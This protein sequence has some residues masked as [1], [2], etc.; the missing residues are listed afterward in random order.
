MKRPCT[1][2]IVVG[3]RFYSVCM[4]QS[5][6][7]F[8]RVWISVALFAA[9]MVGLIG[10]A[11][12]TGWRET[13]DAFGRLSLAQFSILLGLSLLNYGFRCA[14]WHIYIR[15][16][17]IPLSLMSNARHYLGG[18]ALTATPGRVG[19]LIRLRW[20]WRETGRRP[21][22]T[23]SLV[24]VDRAADLTA[25]GLILAL[26]IAVSTVGIQGAW[27]VSIVALL[28]AW[29]ATRPVLFRAVITIGWK[30]LG[31]FPRFFAMLRR[32]ANGL[33]V[34]SV[35]SVFVPTTICGMIGWLAEGYAFYLLLHWM[36]AG[37]ELPT[38]VA[39]FFFAM[40]S[41]SASGLPGGIGGA[42]A[43]M[44]ALLSYQGV[45]LEIAIPATA[46]IRITTL[47]FAIIVGL[48][49]LPFAERLSN[50]ALI[51]A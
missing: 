38:A 25:V 48:I 28:L 13:L 27:T 20:I 47:W 18:F 15:A 26:A 30:F 35:P 19:E 9:F 40:L 4:T 50:K 42:E 46:I 29:I 2:L 5:E 11:A 43:A 33:A 1:S 17:N 3:I 24:L 45:P 8:S 6:T 31:R 36:G 23:G 10:I 32:A 14:R 41:G 21:D 34:F 12:A 51:E 16:L 7:K 22:T 39:I 37:V 44:I 49:T